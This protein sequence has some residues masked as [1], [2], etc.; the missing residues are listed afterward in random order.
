MA[1]YDFDAERAKILEYEGRTEAVERRGPTRRYEFQEP[2]GWSIKVREAY[3]KATKVP[4]ELSDEERE[5]ARN[6]DIQDEQIRWHKENGNIVRDDNEVVANPAGR[7]LTVY[8]AHI[9]SI[10]LGREK[11]DGYMARLITATDQ[12]N[13]HVP[14][15]PPEVGEKRFRLNCEADKARAEQLGYLYSTNH[16]SFRR[17]TGQ[18]NQEPAFTNET[19]ASRHKFSAIVR[20]MQEVTWMIQIIGMAEAVI[21]PEQYKRARAVVQHWEQQSEFKT[22]VTD[23]EVTTTTVL[24]SNTVSDPHWDAT[25]A[26]GTMTALQVW[27]DFDN[28]EGGHFVIPITNRMYAM[29]TDSLVWMLSQ[30]IMH[31]TSRPVT[32]QRFSVV[33]ITQKDL[34]NFDAISLPPTPAEKAAFVRE[35][36]EDDESDSCPFCDQGPYSGGLQSINKHLISIIVRGGDDKHPLDEIT[37]WKEWASAEMAKRGL[38][39]RND[40]SAAKKA[41]KRQLDEDSEAEHEVDQAPG[42]K[43]RK[44]AKLEVSYEYERYAAALFTEDSTEKPLESRLQSHMMPPRLEIP[45]GWVVT[46]P[47]TPVGQPPPTPG[48]TPIWQESSRFP[49]HWRCDFGNDKTM[50]LGGPPRIIGGLGNYDIIV[51]G[52]SSDAELDKVDTYQLILKNFIASYPDTL[53]VDDVLMQRDF[54]LRRNS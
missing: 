18:R 29:Y 4:F 45:A 31:Y 32:G 54:M 9:G 23:R 16:I 28:K 19:I 14:P 46:P 35:A 8:L 15:T 36:R 37:N 30:E 50:Y 53:P 42:P 52:F 2:E 48:F 41:A 24:N 12:F 20:Y 51:F 49:G 26:E 40:R 7:E 27:G 22:I 47:F 17:E 1:S 13:A 43:R 34:A 33:H 38:K 3:D 10:I 44:L 25:D 11:W 5:R 39:R 21:F 6:L